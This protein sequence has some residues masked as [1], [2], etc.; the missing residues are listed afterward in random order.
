VET[1]GRA[2]GPRG[3]CEV[4]HR[5]AAP[6]SHC[7]FYLHIS[8]AMQFL[9][10]Q[11]K[12]R[13]AGTRFLI[14][15]F[16]KM[17]GAAAE[18]LQEQVSVCLGTVGLLHTGVD[19]VSLHAQP[20]STVLDA[21]SHAAECLRLCCHSFGPTCRGAS[22]WACPPVRLRSQMRGGWMSRP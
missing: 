12:S 3:T 15:G 13:V 4:H 18:M 17:G 2:Q 1:R 16:G 11:M 19:V 8:H 5:H 20:T 22:S 7:C 21:T 14:Q 10:K 9:R 6:S